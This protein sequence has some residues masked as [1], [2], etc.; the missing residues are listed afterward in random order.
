MLFWL[1]SGFLFF[2][3]MVTYDPQLTCNYTLEQ[4][5]DDRMKLMLHSSNKLTEL[6]R[7]YCSWPELMAV[8]TV[9]AEST[10]SC[11]WKLWGKTDS[12]KI[13]IYLLVRIKGTMLYK[14]ICLW[15]GNAY[16]Q[17]MRSQLIESLGQHTQ[18]AAKRACLQL[19]SA[20]PNRASPLRGRGLFSPPLHFPI[21]GLPIFLIKWAKWGPTYMQWSV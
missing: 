17:E 6:G 9:V 21:A 13:K 14:D 19:S 5:R 15:A 4:Q 3:V 12:T 11:A 7:I 1:L 16:R 2:G 20:H 18:A 10:L 8:S